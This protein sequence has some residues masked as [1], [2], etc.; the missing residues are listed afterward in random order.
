MKFTDDEVFDFLRV[1]S[2]ILMM[3]NLQFTED[4]ENQAQVKDAAPIEKV[5]HLL[6][7]PVQDFTKGLL[8]PVIKAGR[9]WVAQAR[10][11]QQVNYSV[12]AL[13]RA[14]YE[15]MFGM[16]VD[17]INMAIDTPSSKSTFIGVLDIAGFEIFQVKTRIILKFV[18]DDFYIF[19]SLD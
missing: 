17:R 10:N 8:R 4:K 14:F 9:D 18:V 16:L 1:I 3:G 13:A 5:C 2:A 6:G 11:V 19:I 15:K 12:E 7:I